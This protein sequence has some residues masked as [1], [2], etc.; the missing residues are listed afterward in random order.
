MPTIEQNLQRWDVDHHW[1]QNG[2]EWS[3]TWGDAQAQ[4]YWAIYPRIRSLLPAK[5]ILEIAPGF[6]R[7]S[8]FLKNQC[9]RMMLI[10]L[11]PRCIE[12][13]QQRFSSDAHVT[14]H[15]NDGKSLLMVPE[16]A[17]DFVFSFDSLVHC[18]IDVIE[19]Y[20]D[21]LAKKFTRN[22]AGFIHH[23]NFGECLRLSPG[24]ES[25]VKNKHWRATS[26]CAESFERCCQKVGL[27]CV[28]QELINWGG[29]ILNDC[30]SV[31][32]RKDATWIQ[33]RKTFRNPA[34]MEEAAYIARLATLYK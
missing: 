10:D 7:W 27:Q 15:V 6:G 18:E 2:E 21:Q 34:F 17:V 25:K 3:K 22:G 33:P 16:G 28:S 12:A 5:M 24:D 4:W 9:E 1:P 30:L 19:T 20:L 31:F 13:C 14:C 11:S 26:V 23:S 8:Q 32:T 29:S